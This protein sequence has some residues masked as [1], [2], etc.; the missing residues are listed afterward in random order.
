MHSS[1]RILIIAIT[2]AGCAMAA[3]LPKKAPKSKYANLW[4]N[5]PFTSKP[6]PPE[7]APE[8][9]ILSD[10][11]LGGISPVGGGYLVTLLNKK[12]PEERIVVRPDET[13]PKH[14]FKILEVHRK[15]GDPLGTTVKLASGASIGMVAFDDKLLTLAAPPATKPG[16]PP[17][18]GAIPHP[19][20]PTAV[21]ANQNQAASRMPRPRVV[22]PTGGAPATNAAAPPTGGYRPP[23]APTTIQPAQRTD[24]RSHR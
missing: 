21:P 15:A 4:Q 19:T 6:P 2:M 9:N 7:A 18:T 3:D 13:N 1:S 23:V 14:G 8:A 17:A 5:S 20:T 11:A 10:Y 12:K 16:A 24:H 22:P